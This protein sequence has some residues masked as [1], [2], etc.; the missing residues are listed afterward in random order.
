[1]A[2]LFVD[3]TNP[4][5]KKALELRDASVRSHAARISHQRRI[6]AKSR[7]SPSTSSAEAQHTN[8]DS[9]DLSDLNISTDTA[10]ASLVQYSFDEDK[11]VI[12]ADPDPDPDTDAV[13]SSAHNMTLLSPQSVLIKGQS[14]PFDTSPTPIDAKAHEI[15]LYWRD[16][17]L[18]RR[19][20]VNIKTWHQSTSAVSDWEDAR[21]SLSDRGL[22]YALLA[23][24]SAY[25]VLEI[26]SSDL[27]VLSLTYSQ[28]STV[29]LRERLN[30]EDDS[31]S[32]IVFRHMALLQGVETY[33]RN[34][35]AAVTHGKML[36]HLYDGWLFRG[37]RFD[38]KILLLTLYSDVQMALTFLIRPQ[39]KPSA[40]LVKVFL[41]VCDDAT[42]EE[43]SVPVST[44][45]RLKS[46]L[47]GPALQNVFLRWDQN[48]EIRSF[49]G[50]RLWTFMN[51]M[52]VIN[53]IL[54]IEEKIDRQYELSKSTN[55]TYCHVQ[56]YL[57]LAA[58]FLIRLSTLPEHFATKPHFTAH[59]ALLRRLRHHLELGNILEDKQ[60]YYHARLWALFVGAHSEY[61]AALLSN[62]P[63]AFA[64]ASK[65]WFNVQL[66][67]QAR[68]SGVRRWIHIKEILESFMYFEMVPDPSVWY[69]ELLR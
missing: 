46:Q 50:R 3:S 23:Q 60:F 69:A 35:A 49:Y 66:A 68:M 14:D 31:D 38:I 47:I 44:I 40:K 48:L 62:I 45:Y 11:A 54:D 27:S 64:V 10:N 56:A 42:R 43:C 36:R 7:S 19:H 16:T 67:Q 37:K 58:L 32:L 20:H 41:E 24:V 5:S 39:F 18:F 57:S 1:M 59:T 9:I 51:Q 21:R 52:N 63:R 15:M 4:S 34:Q 61:Q 6:K 26:D 33:A 12:R 25:K 30:K 17:G 22:G 55:T 29:A 53:H 28:R 65:G 13:W 8:T 2:F